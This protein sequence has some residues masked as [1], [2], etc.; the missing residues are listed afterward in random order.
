MQLCILELL[1]L[2]LN[3]T[4]LY[5]GYFQVIT[6]ST[7]VLM[8]VLTAWHIFYAATNYSTDWITGKLLISKTWNLSSN[9]ITSKS[10]YDISNW[11]II[12]DIPNLSHRGYCILISCVWKW[13][14]GYWWVIQVSYQ[15]IINLTDKLAVSKQIS[16]QT[17]HIKINKIAIAHK[18]EIIL[19]KGI[20]FDMSIACYWWYNNNGFLIRT[21]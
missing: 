16:S 13:L 12:N 5:F 3:M 6:Q 20:F 8:Y 1:P 19:C 18:K 21:D 7:C 17:I 11:W 14:I 4:S 9:V 10:R 2:T 15:A